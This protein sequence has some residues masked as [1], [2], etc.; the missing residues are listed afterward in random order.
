MVELTVEHPGPAVL[1]SGARL[2][3]TNHPLSARVARWENTEL[4]EQIYL[5]TRALLRRATTLLG[6]GTP[7]ADRIREILTDHDGHRSRC[8]HPAPAEPTA[9]AATLVFDCRTR[10]ARWASAA[11][12]PRTATAT[13]STDRRCRRP[14][15]CSGGASTAGMSA[16][17]RSSGP[18]P[19]TTYPITAAPVKE[20]PYARPELEEKCW[21]TRPGVCIT[22]VVPSG[23]VLTA[24]GCGRCRISGKNRA[25]TS[26]VHPLAAGSLASLAH[27]GCHGERCA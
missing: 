11:R 10:I 23:R 13:D 12:A 16:T 17:T 18:G 2:A 4:R 27:I 22:A 7:D 25:P 9:T 6:S 3:H 5:S 20:H 8:R 21:H 26:G 24:G 15:V 1:P 14:D 19:P